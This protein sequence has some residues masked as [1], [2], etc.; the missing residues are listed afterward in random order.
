M[1]KGNYVS[2][3]VLYLMEMLAYLTLFVFF[4]SIPLAEYP[5]HAYVLWFSLFYGASVGLAMRLHQ[6]P[7]IWMNG[8]LFLVLYLG[9]VNLASFPP[10]STFL[11][12]VIAFWRMNSLLTDKTD[13]QTWL[14]NRFAWG[15]G[16]LA[17]YC[18]LDFVFS[19]GDMQMGIVR[20]RTPSDEIIPVMLVYFAVLTVIGMV[21][22][23]FLEAR[24]SAGY[25]RQKWWTGQSAF[26]FYTLAI[27]LTAVAL[28]WL[29]VP[30]IRLALAI[31]FTLFLML[32]TEK[33]AG[34]LLGFWDEFVE[35]FR[36]FAKTSARS[37]SGGD[38]ELM[39][40]QEG[41]D[42]FR[43]IDSSFPEEIKIML[44]VLAVL[45]AIFLLWLAIRSRGIRLE[46]VAEPMRA[47]VEIP[48]ERLGK[49]PRTEKKRLEKV[50]DEV[51]KQYRS[52]LVYAQKRQ[53]EIKP[54]DSVW[55]WPARLKQDRPDVWEVINR[56][57]EQR[58][59][60]DIPLDE[61]E[62]KRYRQAIREAK[63]MIKAYADELRKRGENNS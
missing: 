31:L 2:V 5:V 7:T 56:T 59:Y 51:R 19:S 9:A 43:R 28:G 50:N 6:L 3:Y 47:A 32:F 36:Q 21:W 40:T 15:M 27:L 30:A 23:R 49:N 48:K 55:I 37:S 22:W 25:T 18:S 60:A 45:A 63:R 35:W 12:C 53:V 4:F 16:A 17:L 13:S 57:Y 39:P 14:L 62:R 44:L 46:P 33:A 41:W 38:D 8:V 42:L 1:R 61:E 24:V 11:L 54:S 52:L 29:L 10:L 34:W 58:R 26:V 20:G